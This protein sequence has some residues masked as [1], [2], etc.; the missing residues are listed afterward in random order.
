ML[1]LGKKAKGKRRKAKVK[2]RRFLR[3]LWNNFADFAFLLD[4]S[5][6]FSVNQRKIVDTRGNIDYNY[7]SFPLEKNIKQTGGFNA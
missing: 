3:I 2:E 4:F 5:L 6:E 1:G 7:Y